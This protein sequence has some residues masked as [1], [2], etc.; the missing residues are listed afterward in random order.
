MGSRVH[1]AA[2]QSSTGSGTQLPVHLSNGSTGLP[3]QPVCPSLDCWEYMEG[4]LV[5]MMLR[6]MPVLDH[7]ENVLIH[8]HELHLIRRV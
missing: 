8:L 7:A 3:N 2:H 5:F 1:S 4:G 6:A